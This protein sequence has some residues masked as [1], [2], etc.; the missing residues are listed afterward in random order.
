MKVKKK[1]I[2][3]ELRGQNIFPTSTP[4]SVYAEHVRNIIL[5]EIGRQNEAEDSKIYLEVL[6][7]KS[8][9]YENSIFL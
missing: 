9:P 4:P 8:K 1:L 2:F 6:C 7:P 5:R 3:D